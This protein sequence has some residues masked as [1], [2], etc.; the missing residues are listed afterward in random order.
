LSAHTS[1]KRRVRLGIT[2][3][4][5]AAVRANRR[6]QSVVTLSAKEAA[7]LVAFA[8]LCLDILDTKTPDA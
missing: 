8:E 6:G 3:A 1:P 2:D 4:K 7:D 5:N